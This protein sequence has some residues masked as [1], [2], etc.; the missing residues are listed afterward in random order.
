V[1]L[2]LSAKTIR[3]A[4]VL[5]VIPLAV[6]AS[7]ALALPYF[8]ARQGI[9]NRIRS[10]L[11][12]LSG[13]P[14]SLKGDVTITLFPRFAA[15]VQDVEVGSFDAI[16]APAMRAKT[17]EVELSRIATMKSQ[18]K[19]TSLRISDADIR[20]M[21]DSAGGWLPASI[22]SPLGPAILAE[23]RTADAGAAPS[24]TSRLTSWDIGSMRMTNSRL[25]LVSGGAAEVIRDADLMLS[26]PNTAAP[27]IASGGGTWRGN[28]ARFSARLQNPIPMAAGNNSAVT[29][30]AE[31]GLATMSF[32][33]FANLQ[34]FF[35]TNGDL[36]FETPSMGQL[37]SWIGARVDP[38]ASMGSMGLSAK[39]TAKDDHL[40]FNDAVINFN[41]N[42]ASG[43]FEMKPDGRIP[44]L[45]G[46]LAFDR[47]DLASFLS[48]FSVGI[49]PGS[50]RPGV[51]FLQQINL[52][53]R[54]SAKAANAGPLAL[55]EIAAAIRIKDGFAEFD[56]G[57]AAL[58]GGR[59]QGGMKI[60]EAAGLPDASIRLRFKDL[61]SAR[62]FGDS[63]RPVITAPLA[64]MAEAEGKYA[65]FL[66]FLLAAR[67]VLEMQTQQG[68]V[69]NFALADFRQRLDLGALFNLPL[70]YA[71][72][73]PLK[74]ASMKARI[75]DGV[76]I[77]TSGLVSLG[78][79]DLVV[80]GALPVVSDGLAL[81]GWLADAQGGAV[82]RF[83]IG[84]SASL[85]FVTPVN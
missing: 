18:L 49:G 23:Q 63:G 25:S 62:L 51:N 58:A 12:L 30:Q 76:I 75:E 57:D 42:P 48:A 69:R 55:T 29:L 78:G 82:H 70:T 20:L 84:G 54:L 24:D 72:I 28:P 38:G 68:N 8:L 2:S 14:V 45:S 80:T 35:F 65:G 59:L 9:E 47:L 26:W 19:I 74:A 67:G 1:K 10:E 66:P 71:G 73:E 39:L 4:L 60:K 32:D 21:R 36:K 41:G 56:L 31:S 53:L 61:D 81:S 52:D 40:N 15:I 13:M 50:T 11:S 37:L 5:L 16:N 7:A 83:F 27:L 22:A 34:N 33:G 3:S 44:A 79:G 17:L 6:L 85:P 43:V 77:V 46:T 64:G